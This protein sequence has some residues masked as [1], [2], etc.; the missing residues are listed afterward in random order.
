MFASR[1][2]WKLRKLF[3]V[4]L[5]STI[6]SLNAVTGMIAIEVRAGQGRAPV[7]RGLRCLPEGSQ[8][9]HP[10]SL[11]QAKEWIIKRTLVQ[12]AGTESMAL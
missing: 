10:S 5:L 6:S 9:S 1:P 11:L 3:P 4:V 2:M 8:I 7:S 12:G